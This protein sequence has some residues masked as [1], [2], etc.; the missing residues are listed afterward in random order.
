MWGG[1][2]KPTKAVKTFGPSVGAA[3]A[4]Q[5]GGIFFP[6]MLLKCGLF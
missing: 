5:T 4:K 6:T 1:D 2:A 3:N